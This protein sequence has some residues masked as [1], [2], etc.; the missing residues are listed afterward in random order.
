MTTSFAR[1]IR[2]LPFFNARFSR[3]VTLIELMVIAAIIGMLAAAIAPSLQA[4]WEKEPAAAILNGPGKGAQNAYLEARVSLSRASELPAEIGKTRAP[5]LYLAAV[6]QWQAILDQPLASPDD[7]A[8][9][10]ETRA[11]ERA[12][13]KAWLTKRGVE[14]ADLPKLIKSLEAISPKLS[15]KETTQV[16]LLASY[17]GIGA[18][19]G[20][21][22]NTIRSLFDQLHRLGA[23]DHGL[24]ASGMRNPDNPELRR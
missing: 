14:P 11:K 10:R 22:K 18:A 1:P 24:L 23:G 7:A 3:G 16:E 21:K 6:E 2:P 4:R 17:E 20:I 8:W 15:P 12:A 5:G 9:V 19:E 13:A